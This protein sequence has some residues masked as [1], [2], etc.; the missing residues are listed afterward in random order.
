MGVSALVCC[1][2]NTCQSGDELRREPVLQFWK[3][4]QLEHERPKRKVVARTCFFG[5]RPCLLNFCEDTCQLDG[6]P[7]APMLVVGWTPYGAF[8]FREHARQ[9][10]D[11]CSDHTPSIGQSSHQTRSAAAE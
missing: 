7:F 3:R 9:Y 11:I 2:G 4:G 8:D 6:K 1:L 10:V 5:P